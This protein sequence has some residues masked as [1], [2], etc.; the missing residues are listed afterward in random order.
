MALEEFKAK[1]RGAVEEAY[2]KGNVDVMNELYVP[3]VI[4]HQPPFPDMNGLEAYKHHIL[5]A[6]QAYSD[7]QFEWEEMIGEGNTMAF[8]AS[9]RMKHTGVSQ[10]LPVSPTG[11]EVVMKACFFIH[12]R[13]DRIIEVFEYKEYLGFL[14]RLGVIQPLKS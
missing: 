6:R 8:R 4:I 1:Y 14:Q 13:N 12:L 9:W 11:Q 10:K 5:D 7:I 2:Y 3:D